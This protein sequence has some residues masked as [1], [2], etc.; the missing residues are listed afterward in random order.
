MSK[1][2]EGTAG[3]GSLFVSPGTRA[4]PPQRAGDLLGAPAESAVG[5]DR[6]GLEDS[7]RVRR[8]CRLG[9]HQLVEAVRRHGQYRVAP[10]PG[11]LVQ[12]RLGER[13]RRREAAA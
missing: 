7:R 6:A 1:E 13:E 3:R 10:L 8:A 4:V 11:E 5:E 12:L 9:G 2:S